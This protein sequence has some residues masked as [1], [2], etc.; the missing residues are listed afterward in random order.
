MKNIPLRKCLV[1]N[2][3]LPKEELFR[4]VKTRDGEV[5]LDL[6][7]KINGRGAYIKRDESSIKKAKQ[8]H[9]LNKAFDMNVDEQIYDEMLKALEKE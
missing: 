3:M 9:I 1:N 7:N 8:K 4:V 2:Q 6:S 5:L